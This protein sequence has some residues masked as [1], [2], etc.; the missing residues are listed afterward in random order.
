MKIYYYLG[1]LLIV[2]V[3][4][5]ILLWGYTRIVSWGYFKTKKE[6]L[7]GLKNGIAKQK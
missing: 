1:C 3:V 2:L 7:E 6:Y 4:V 5:P